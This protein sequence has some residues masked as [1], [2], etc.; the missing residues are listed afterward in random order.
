[1]A[2]KKKKK[3]LVI[4]DENSFVSTM[5]I[6]LEF[7]G[8]EIL[9]AVNGQEGIEVVREEKPDIVLLDI[10]MAKIDGF[11]VCRILKFDKR[12]Q[13]IPIIMVTAKGQEKDK[14]IGHQVGA[15]AYITKP[16]E[17]PALL[18]KIKSLLKE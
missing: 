17:M 15:D 10:M 2:E 12:Y 14:T 1:M 4:D 13:E 9:T 5:K 18:E 3:I 7:Q 11:Q 16:F 8:Y 6:A